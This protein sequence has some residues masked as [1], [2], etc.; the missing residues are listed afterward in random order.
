PAG[1]SPSMKCPP[2]SVEVAL[3]ELSSCTLAFGIP[4][5]SA[6]TTLP[7]IVYCAIA[8]EETATDT[9]NKKQRSTRLLS[10]KTQINYIMFIERP[11]L[12]LFYRIIRNI[13]ENNC[14]PAL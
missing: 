1:T 14:Y 12:P 2:S 3:L 11:K 6:V 4:L 5:F 13:C 7:P 8:T 9:K 10:F